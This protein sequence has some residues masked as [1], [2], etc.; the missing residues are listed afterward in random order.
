MGVG[1]KL[2]GHSGMRV[3][4][5]WQLGWILTFHCSIPGSGAGPATLRA[6]RGK[7]REQGSHSSLMPWAGSWS[8]PGIRAGLSGHTRTGCFP[9]IPTFHDLSR[10]AQPPHIPRQIPCSSRAGRRDPCGPGGFGI[11]TSPSSDRCVWDKA[12]G[13]ARRPAGAEAACL[14]QLRSRI[15][16]AFHKMAA[17]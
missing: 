13:A 8:I 5:M 16:V 2:R 14:E 6:W 7:R 11:L 17:P 9:T 12:L 15:Q 1:G 10:A 4:A 3:Q